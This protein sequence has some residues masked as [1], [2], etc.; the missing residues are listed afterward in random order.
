M[1]WDVNGR[2]PNAFATEW[3]STNTLTD[4]T[5]LAMFF[6]TTR[7]KDSHTHSIYWTYR[8]LILQASIGL[9]GRGVL[10]K[11]IANF[12]T[13]QRQ[14]NCCGGCTQPGTRHSKCISKNKKDICHSLLPTGFHTRG[15]LSGSTRS[16]FSFSCTNSENFDSAQANEISLGETWCRSTE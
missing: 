2:T 8:G 16:Q 14:P 4:R 12:Y 7:N 10:S 11:A 6:K 3:N 9:L 13:T 5:Q 1:Q 15:L